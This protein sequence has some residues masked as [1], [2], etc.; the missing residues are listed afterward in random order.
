MDKSL[1]LLTPKLNS[2]DVSMI[3]Q[4]QI[5]K[6]DIATGER[7]SLTTVGKPNQFSNRPFVLSAPSFNLGSEQTCGSAAPSPVWGWPECRLPPPRDG[8]LALAAKVGSES[9][10]LKNTEWA[11]IAEYFSPKVPQANNGFP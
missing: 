1:K 11:G 9:I 5:F 10:L 8:W 7:L 3:Q 6:T 2:T 4:R